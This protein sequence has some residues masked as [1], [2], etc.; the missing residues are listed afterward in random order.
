MSSAKKQDR[1][2]LSRR[3]FIK[4]GAAGLAGASIL[5][6]KIVSA[7]DPWLTGEVSPDTSGPF[8]MMSW[9]GE[10]E[11]RKWLL[12]TKRFFDKYYP[13]MEWN[14]DWGLSWD[15][16]WTKLSTLLAG[17]SPLEMVWMHDSRL[18]VFADRELLLPLDDYLANYPAPGWPDHFYPSQVEAFQHNGKQYAFPYDWA[19]GGWYVNLDILEEAG[20]DVPT[21][22]WTWDQTLEAAL[23]MKE[24]G[25]W[26]I[27]G[28]TGA[29]GWAGGLYWIIK[30]FGGD[31]WDESLT[32]SKMADPA[33]VAGFQFLRDCMW[34][35]EV[36][37]TAAALSGIGMSEE[38]AFASGRIGL[39]YGLNDVSFRFG[40][41]IGDKFKWTVAPTPTGPAGRFQFSGGSAW[42]IPKTSTQP[43]M[44]YELIRWVLANP[45][46]LPTTAVMGGALVGNMDFW[47]F[48]MPPESTGIT[49]A[50]KHAF[51]EM[52]KENPCYPNYHIKYQEWEQSVF[53]K[54][55]DP[56]FV[57]EV[58]DAAEACQCAH[59][60]TQEILDSL[61]KS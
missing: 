37:P 58:A 8:R 31:F 20:V 56:L 18:H 6:A 24:A 54:C 51:Y 5:S 57:G 2:K 27:S 22:D 59:E 9:E 17:G 12:H 29:T 26:G 50:F 40:E 41:A 15:E 49:E 3:E 16:Y 55:I 53:T 7:Q 30:C 25:Y 34:K 11:M 43:D 28:F 60:G 44:A 14:N 42:C 32:E 61:P 46:N 38:L 48:G 10:G 47:E 1:Q 21:E 23:K 35:H 36:S 33:T 13:N 19:P 4:V 39:H 45:D 52:G